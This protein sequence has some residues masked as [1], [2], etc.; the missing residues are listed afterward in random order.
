MAPPTIRTITA[1]AIMFS[2]RIPRSDV[3]GF[4]YTAQRV[5][6]FEFFVFLCDH[7]GKDRDDGRDDR[8]TEDRHPSRTERAAGKEGAEEEGEE[9]DGVAD[10]EL[11][12]DT[13]PQ[14]F[15]ALDLGV[16]RTNRRKTRRGEQV[17]HQERKARNDRDA[18]HIGGGDGT[19]RFEVFVDEVFKHKDGCQGGNDTFFGDET[20]DRRRRKL[21]QCHADDGGNDIRDGGRDRCQNGVCGVF[22]RLE[23]PT[24][25]LHHIHDEV[26]DENDRTRFDD[27]RPTS[28]AHRFER[29]SE[30]GYFVFGKFDDEEGFSGFVAGEFVDQ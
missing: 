16:H 7:D 24:V 5:F 19:D 28:L 22:H 23:V 8:P 2:I 15:F 3:G 12:T 25:G 13:R 18:A 17:E 29:Q 20:G 14:P 26:T 30:G 11:Q 27:I 9:T 6:G 4:F 10:R 21:P 1:T